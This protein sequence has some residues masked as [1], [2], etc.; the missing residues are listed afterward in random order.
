MVNK[1][2]LQADYQVPKTTNLG[3]K[4]CSDS[5]KWNQEVK[6]AYS[7]MR[8]QAEIDEDWA[9][10]TLAATSFC[11]SAGLGVGFPGIADSTVSVG[12]CIN[13]GET[14]RSQLLRLREDTKLE[15]QITALTSG[16]VGMN[17]KSLSRNP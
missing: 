3:Y 6:D 11:A 10:D 12:V 14:A 13:L 7:K 16:S 9:L 4:N 5:D 8:T 2:K 1:Q 17:T 15:E